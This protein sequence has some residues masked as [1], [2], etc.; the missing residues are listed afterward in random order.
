MVGP[1]YPS[2]LYK[3]N[4]VTGWGSVV[5]SCIKYGT[6]PDIRSSLSL[7]IGWL[8]HWILF[9]SLVISNNYGVWDTSPC[10]YKHSLP[11]VILR[12][13]FPSSINSVSTGLKGECGLLMKLSLTTICCIQCRSICKLV[14]WSEPHESHFCLIKLVWQIH[15]IVR[16]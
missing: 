11:L 6:H 4:K 2:W 9:E 12:H 1:M 10:G 14:P 3:N 7:L 8:I 15:Q 13:K 5:I 16:Y